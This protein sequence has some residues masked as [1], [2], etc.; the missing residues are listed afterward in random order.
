MEPLS[1]YE[2]NKEKCKAQARAYQAAHREKFRDYFRDYYAKNKTRLRANYRNWERK[3]K[4]SATPQAS[5]VAPLIPLTP[6]DPVDPS[7][8]VE[9]GSFT[10]TF[11]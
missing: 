11:E 6:L 3:K 1:Y 10:V 8:V 7:L 5:P 9:Q 4:E 2:R